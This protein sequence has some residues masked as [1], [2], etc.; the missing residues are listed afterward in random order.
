[1]RQTYS[2]QINNR[3]CQLPSTD[4]NCF[5][6]K[7]VSTTAV[8]CFDLGDDYQYLIL[9]LYFAM[10]FKNTTHERNDKPQ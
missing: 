5:Q 3:P 4:T 10:L 1:M 8:H 6:I 2:E 7:T 9:L